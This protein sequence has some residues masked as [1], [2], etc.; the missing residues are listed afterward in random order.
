MN[1][2]Y[3]TLTWALILASLGHSQTDSSSNALQFNF[4]NSASLAYRYRLSEASELRAGIDVSGSLSDRRRYNVPRY[5]A[6]SLTFDQVDTRTNLNLRLSIEYLYAFYTNE[7]VSLYFSAGPF[8]STTFWRD[9]YISEYA[10]GV[11]DVTYRRYAWSIGAILGVGVQCRVYEF[12]SVLGEYT[13]T[14]SYG[15]EGSEPGP[16]DE[17]IIS[18]GI[19]K[20]HIGIV[21]RF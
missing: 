19:E 3:L 1:R 5:Y 6:D 14:L 18:F 9:H 4:V 12:V 16:P 13:G 20:I 10:T 7:N 21:V 15:Y 11:E 2:I 8:R 17:R